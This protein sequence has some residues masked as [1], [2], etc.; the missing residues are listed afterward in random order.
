MANRNL[1]WM[2]TIKNGDIFQDNFSFSKETVIN[3]VIKDL[4]N[5]KHSEKRDT[6]LAYIEYEGNESDPHE[7]FK[8]LINQNFSMLDYNIERPEEN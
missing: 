7:A 2:E 8:N 3:A 4:K 1:Y 6:Y 5:Y